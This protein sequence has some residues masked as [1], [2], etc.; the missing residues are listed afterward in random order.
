[1]AEEKQMIKLTPTMHLRFVRRTVKLDPFYQPN[2]AIVRALQQLHLGD[3]GL[4]ERWL[5][6]PDAGE[7]IDDPS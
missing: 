4:T 1:M 2:T 6:V 5:D 3:D 7:I